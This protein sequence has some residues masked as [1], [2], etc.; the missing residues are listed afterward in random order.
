[1]EL[2]KKVFVVILNYNHREDL[3]ETIE[4]FEIQEFPG[5]RL[6]VSDNGSTDDSID[7]LKQ[8]KPN[9]DIIENSENLGWAEGNNV[10]IR[11][12][13]SN[14]AD[15]VLLANNDL[16]FSDPMIVNKLV[17]YAQ[18]G[19]KCLAGVSEYLYYSSSTL[20]S[21]GR[22]FLDDPHN[23]CNPMRL[24]EI[25]RPL[26]SQ[27]NVVDY[28]PG[29][30]VLIP[31]EVFYKIGLIDDDFFLYSEDADFGYRAWLAGYPS[32]VYFDLRILHKV[33]VTS[34]SRSRLKLYYQ[35]RNSLR[36]WRKHRSSLGKPNTFIL[37]YHYRWL[38][39]L[40][41]LIVEGNFKGAKGFLEGYYKGVV[42]K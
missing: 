5:L 17:G 14:G 7:W 24:K 1:M 23:T 30:F 41:S 4:S 31:S 18:S 12:A 3:Q 40:A 19:R 22:Y 32:Y 33:S 9:I 39:L 37:I 2:N 38:K 6:V 10:G 29:S 15:Y 13:L 16:S 25:F 20:Y 34:G 27:A 21:E 28:V 8:N 11:F 36:F 42:G 26:T 35:T